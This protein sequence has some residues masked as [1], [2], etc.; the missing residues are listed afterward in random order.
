[1]RPAVCE[2]NFTPTSTGLTSVVSATRAGVAPGP[3]MLHGHVCG[4][5]PTVTV[6][7]GFGLSMFP[8]SSAARVRS[9]VVPDDP[10]VFHVYVHVPRPVAGCHVWPLSVDTSTP[11]TTPPPVS[12]A[13]PLIVTWLPG[14]IEA[15][16]AGAVIVDV[17]AV[18]SLETRRGR[19]SRSCSVDG[20]TPMS[21]NRLTVACCMPRRRRPRSRDRGSSRG[22]RTTAPCPAPNTSAPLGVR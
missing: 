13:V 8:L 15:F 1:M 11:P 6:T 14:V 22:P 20:C 16:G 5:E 2:R 7:P 12:L 10:E 18:E 17:G 3:Q 19:S 21:A 4:P 9:V